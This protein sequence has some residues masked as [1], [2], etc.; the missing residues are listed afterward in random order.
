MF[1]VKDTSCWI[2]LETIWM[3]FGCPT[4]ALRLITWSPVLPMCWKRCLAADASVAVGSSG[5]LPRLD[6]AGVES[7]ELVVC[8]HSFGGKVAL[9][10]TS[11][12]V[13]PS[14]AAK[15]CCQAVLPQ[16]R[17]RGCD[18]DLE[19]ARTSTEKDLDL[20][21]GSRREINFSYFNLCKVT[22]YTCIMS[23]CRMFLEF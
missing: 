2:H 9:D 7:A 14:C 17:I 13:L 16:L 11:A 3:A 1:L 21:L 22:P 20:R 5:S 19:S 23:I 6:H 12:A 4:Q 8:G 15:L 10:T 18:G